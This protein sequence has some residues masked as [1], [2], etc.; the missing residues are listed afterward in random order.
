VGQLRS[1]AE[2]AEDN[3]QIVNGEYEA[4]NRELD[5]KDAE[6]TSLERK[7]DGRGGEGTE[8][9]NLREEIRDLQAQIEQY[10]TEKQELERD[11]RQL[12]E[13]DSRVGRERNEERSNFQTVSLMFE[14]AYIRTLTNF[15]FNCARRSKRR[16]ALSHNTRRRY[17]H[18]LLITD[19]S[20]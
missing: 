8:M 3:L 7:L 9:Q 4:L 14:R 17:V 13:K 12:I 1:T 10:E 11:A 20:D 18:F 5:L 6:I 2:K 15:K 19:V 16:N